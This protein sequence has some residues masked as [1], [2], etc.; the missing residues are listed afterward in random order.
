MLVGSGDVNF[1]RILADA[2]LGSDLILT[3]A[4]APAEQENFALPRRQGVERSQN[5]GSALTRCYPLLRERG[6]GRVIVE[7]RDLLYRFS[8]PP[9][10]FDGVPPD[11]VERHISRD[12]I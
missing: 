9:S 12:A 10:C 3:L 2:E 11:M 8:S 7:R 4:I 5:G 6:I 1:N